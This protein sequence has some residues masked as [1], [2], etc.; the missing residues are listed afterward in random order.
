ML[1]LGFKTALNELYKEKRTDVN[2]DFSGGDNED[3][4]ASIESYF[5]V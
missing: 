2:I 1:K 5:M 4:E 3:F